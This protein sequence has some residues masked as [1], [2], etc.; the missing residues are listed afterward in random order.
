MNTD[1]PAGV[2]IVSDEVSELLDEETV[3][4]RDAE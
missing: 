4:R 1:G 2:L 3:E